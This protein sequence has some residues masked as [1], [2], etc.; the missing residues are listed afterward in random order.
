M[1][2]IYLLLTMLTLLLSA[3][4]P[5]SV[6]VETDSFSFE[7][8]S[9]IPIES[10]STIDF[11]KSKFEMNNVNK[12]KENYPEL[13]KEYSEMDKD[14]LLEQICAEVVDLHLMEERVKTFMS[15]FSLN[16]SNTNY[17]IESIKSIISSKQEH[18]INVFCKDLLDDFKSD[19]E[20]IEDLRSRAQQV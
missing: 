14:Q 11:V 2:S 20:R 17:T 13:V 10:D 15:E 19:N 4:M 7:N 1:K 3:S 8:V 9:E 16:L 12:L 5:A 18:D 6:F